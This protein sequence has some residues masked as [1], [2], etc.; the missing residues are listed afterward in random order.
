[1]KTHIMFRRVLTALGF[2]AA[3]ALPAAPAQA[4]TNGAPQPKQDGASAAA[5]HPTDAEIASLWSHVSNN[6]AKS[7]S[8]APV[9]YDLE[10]EN[11][12][13][14]GAVPG[15]PNVRRQAVLREIVPLLR[16]K[17]DAANIAMSPEL[18]EV[19]IRDLKL[20]ASSVQ[21][22]LEAL[23][24]ASGGKFIWRATQLSSNSMLP[25]FTLEPSEQ[26]VKEKGVETPVR[27]QVEVFNF[28]SYF[29]HL[30]DTEP[31]DDAKFQALKEQTIDRTKEIVGTT[32]ISLHL[33]GQTIQFQFHQGANLLV[34]IGTQDAINVARKVINAMIGQPG[35]PTAGERTIAV[36]GRGNVIG[37]V[38]T[39]GPHI[40]RLNPDGSI[41]N[42]FN[43]A[44][45]GT[46]SN[47]K[48]Q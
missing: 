3:L 25:L 1:M 26:F 4:Q 16:E 15:H 18:G 31:G 38:F 17:H 11:G 10:I 13:L 47:Q 8:G 37:G 19:T 21:E 43:P 39:P 46:N 14:L 5:N 30:R 7:Y 44:P 22:E 45:P 23:R 36:D 41:D 35:G 2:A 6:L 48:N 9:Q 42:S 33:Q 27:T 28:S 34:V 12:M 32:I 29:A 20:Y 24:V 40:I